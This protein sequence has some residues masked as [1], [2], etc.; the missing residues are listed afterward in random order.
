M[1][2]W[3][4]TDR[5]RSKTVARRS[6]GCPP[7]KGPGEKGWGLE[8]PCSSGEGVTRS[9]G[10]ARDLPCC[11]PRGQRNFAATSP[12]FSLPISW[13]EWAASG[14]DFAKPNVSVRRTPRLGRLTFPTW[15]GPG[16]VPHRSSA[17]HLHGQP[18]LFWASS[19]TAHSNT[20]EEQIQEL[21]S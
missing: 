18:P 6:G 11:H 15:R 9:C 4:Q 14:G 7:L 3:R 20:P 5:S 21:E 13:L 2:D 16:M 8:V 19:T 17:E 1:E 12:E 10:A